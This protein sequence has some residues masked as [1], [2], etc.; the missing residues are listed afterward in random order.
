MFGSTMILVGI[1]KYPYDCDDKK[2]YPHA[3][4]YREETPGVGWT[5]SESTSYQQHALLPMDTVTGLQEVTKMQFYEKL[6]IQTRD[7][8]SKVVNDYGGKLS[9][10]PIAHEYFFRLDPAV[11]FGKRI[12]FGEIDGD[13]RD[14]YY[15]TA[16]IY[17]K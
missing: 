5:H 16:E 4:I 15:L 3:A 17:N 11:K 12:N 9:F 13:R 10:Y 14:R 1:G 8:V 6:F 7:V 2:R